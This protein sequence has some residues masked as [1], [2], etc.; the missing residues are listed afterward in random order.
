[1]AA[2]KSIEVTVET[3]DVEGAGFDG[4]A[5][6]GF[7]GIEFFF[8][9]TDADDFERGVVTEY[10]FNPT[11]YGVTE[12]D[13]ARFPV[14]IRNTGS[15]EHPYSDW[16]F[17]AATL[18]IN[19]SPAVRY[20]RSFD[21]PYHMYGNVVHLRRHPEELGPDGFDVVAPVTG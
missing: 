12:G 14:Y 13:V 16:K 3:A 18:R 6:L 9:D 8:Y 20:S 15:F 11:P 19:G 1:M 5:Y 10:V 21:V 4:F 2:V 17:K 7:G